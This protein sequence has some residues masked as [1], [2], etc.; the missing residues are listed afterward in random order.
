MAAA[1]IAVARP[2]ILGESP[3]WDA[4]SATLWW[5]DIRAPEILAWSPASGG[6]RSW[7][8]P[9]L[10]GSIVP[11]RAGGLLVGLQSGFHM[12]EPD[13]GALAFVAA[14]ETELPKNRPND[15]RC[16][17]AG[18][19]WCGTMEDYG[20]SARGTLYRMDA[21]RRL[22]AIDGP[23]FVPNSICF[24]PD[25]R[26]M[27]FTDTRR[28]DILVFDYDEATGTRSSPRVL[29]AADA[30]PGRPDGSTV[31]AEGCVWNARYGGGCV[32]RITPHGRVDRIVELPVSQPTSCAFGGP[33][34]DELYVTTA[35]QRLT[36]EQRAR[37]PAAGAIL[38]LRS[39][40]TG[41]PDTPF[42]G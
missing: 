25:G 31:D 3:V 10:V 24:T 40:V 12:F 7:R 36:N 28:G 38:A 1:E 9:A 11:R 34:L 2:C 29:L 42:A 30:A 37:Q 15:A 4:A 8:M 6:V 19:Y 35:A 33:R 26:R 20:E 23:F 18:R 22:E 17:R 39:G 21:D 41:V 16:D 27:V 14:P 5:V 13:T 32:V